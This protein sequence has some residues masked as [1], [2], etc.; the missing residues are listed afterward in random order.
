MKLY[1]READG[2]D[3]LKEEQH[4]LGRE[5]LASL[6]KETYGIEN[7]VIAAAENGK[8]YLPAYPDIFF[9]I[10]HCGSCVAAAVSHRPV[11]VDVEKRFAFRERMAKKIC[12]GG[13]Y[14]LLKDLSEFEQEKALNILWSRKESFLK[15]LGEGIRRDLRTIFVGL[16]DTQISLP[17]GTFEFQQEQNDRYTLVICQMADA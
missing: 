14:A 4:A 6:L 5:G 11:G 13:E 7:A 9:N 2:T 15:C 1:L 10:S 12:S 8:P 16:Y 17:E 3:F